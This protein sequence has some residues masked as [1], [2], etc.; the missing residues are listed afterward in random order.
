MKNFKL[1]ILLCLTTTYSF[2]FSQADGS[3]GSNFGY[4]L[5]EFIPPSFKLSSIEESSEIESFLSENLKSYTLTKFDFNKLNE[6]ALS[7]MYALQFVMKDEQKSTLLTLQRR[8]IRSEEFVITET[9]DK[10]EVKVIKKDDI[11]NGNVRTFVGYVDNDKTKIA[12]FVIYENSL[13]GYIHDEE[14]KTVVYFTSLND[15]FKSQN[16]NLVSEKNPLLIFNLSS[17][18]NNYD[19]TCGTLADM[20]NNESSSPQTAEKGYFKECE[21]RFLE[22]AA[23]GDVA[24]RTKYGNNSANK[25]L[26]RLFLVEGIYT[27]NFNLAFIINHINIMGGNVDLYP[28]EYSSGK[29]N[30]FKNYWNANFT[31]TNRDVAVLYTGASAMKG[32]NGAKNVTGIAFLNTICNK[33][34]SYMIVTDQ[35]GNTKTGAHELG[36]IL[37]S[38]HDNPGNMGYGSDPCNSPYPYADPI[39]CT[40]VNQPNAYFF[41]DY[42]RDIILGT[43]NSNSSCLKQYSNGIASSPILKTWTNKRNYRWIGSWFVN[44]NDIKLVGNFD[45]QDNDE[46]LFFVSPNNDWVGIMD[47]S[48]DQGTDWYHLWSNGG[49]SSFGWLANIATIGKF[50]SGD[51]NGDGIHEILTISTDNQRSVIQQFSAPNAWQLKYAAA[52]NYIAGWQI[53][54]NDQ[55]IVADFNGDG[56]DELLCINS[57][58]WAQLIKFSSSFSPQTIW[59]NNGNGWIGNDYAYAD[60]WLTGKYTQA[61]RDELMR[62][63]GTWVSTQKF[64]GTGWDLT[65]SQWGANHFA[66]MNILPLNS[67]QTLLSGDFDSDSKT[68]V[69]NLN[70]QWMATADYK[71]GTFVQNYNNWGTGMMADWDLTGV[72]EYLMVQASP[73]ARKQILAYKY[74]GSS[75]TW[76]MSMFR[77]NSPLYNF[78][79]TNEEETEHLSEVHSLNK[80]RIYPNPAPSF[81]N[82]ELLGVTEVNKNTYITI[83]DINGRL[84]KTNPILSSSF[85]V[86]LEG[87]APGVYFISTILE[88]TILTSKFIKYE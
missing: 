20:V 62:F 69:I 15:F 84:L 42:T 25:I 22:I 3:D 23:E 5:N 1:I 78:K 68:E 45:G 28:S 16:S 33:S 40:N 64:N 29:L 88:N 66:N 24:W 8:D 73:Y 31:G 4:T 18:K 72:N 12:R 35:V 47:F 7:N 60:K 54:S 39:M 87:L 74:D 2:V 58:G 86:N 34:M 36:H 67:T 10:G 38:L 48:C 43:I 51:F 6:M 14:K 52:N 26:E 32:D 44:Q 83:S 49:S 50:I 70:Q 27:H 37:G 63:G 65:W 59:T 82:V 56:S 57:N 46:E 21:P 79:P 41:S 13:T 30:Q 76:L 17:L 19:E 75:K 77:S 81:L 11:E 80:L 55:Y 71:N 85:V 61:S 53:R 9:N